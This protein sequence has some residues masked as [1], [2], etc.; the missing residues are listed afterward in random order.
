MKFVHQRVTQLLKRVKD[1]CVYKILH[2]DDPPHRLALG[3][4]IGMFVTF[5]P[6][7]GI[8]TFLAIFL[9]WLL[10]ANKLVGAPLVWLSNPF[11]FI[12]IYYP[13]YWV[14]CKLLGRPTGGEEWRQILDSWEALL[15]NPQV[16]WTDRVE[17][18]WNSLWQFMGPLGLGCAIVATA[19]G[20]V[21]YYL[22]LYLIRRYRFLRWGQLMPPHLTPP[23]SID[24]TQVV[25]HQTSPGENAA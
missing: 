14:G 23:E 2:A 10:G 5:T 4:A 12:P 25:H 8:Q 17:F 19:V 9:S 7:I 1:F 20:V 13:C 11:T 22:S 16:Q 15:A 21:S 18:W 24:D 6:F 3:I